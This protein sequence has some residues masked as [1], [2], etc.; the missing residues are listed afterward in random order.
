MGLNCRTVDF[1]PHGLLEKVR[2]PF[3][4]HSQI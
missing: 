3:V 1:V 4:V 2:K